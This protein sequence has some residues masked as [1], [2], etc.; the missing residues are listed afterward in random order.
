MPR[1]HFH[2]RAHA[3]LLRDLDGTELPDLAAARQHGESVARELMRNADAGK[4]QW[5]LRVEDSDDARQFDVFFVDV[6][7]RLAAFPPQLRHLASL[8]C[9][10]LGAIID[11]MCD[12]RATAIESRILLAR[13]RRKPQLVIGRGV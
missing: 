9:R 1:F 3:T 13:A 2:L 6:D 8:A 12:L 7:P 4:C 5:S 10:R 11:T